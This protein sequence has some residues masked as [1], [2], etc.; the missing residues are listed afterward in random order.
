M[1]NIL[2]EI[3]ETAVQAEV[4]NTL[5]DSIIA[6]LFIQNISQQFSHLI[7]SLFFWTPKI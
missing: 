3:T 2:L 5:R 1:G 6:L 4:D 7:L